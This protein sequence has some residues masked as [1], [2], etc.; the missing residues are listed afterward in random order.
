MPVTTDLGLSLRPPNKFLAEEPL[1]EKAVVSSR[2]TERS[3]GND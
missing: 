3:V 2:G 1:G